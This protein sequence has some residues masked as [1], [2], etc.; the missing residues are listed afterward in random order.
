MRIDSNTKIS[1][2]IRENALSIEVLA[3]VNRNFEK[4]R[5]PILRKVLA[6]RVNVLQAAKMGGVHPEVLLQRLQSIGFM[7][8]FDDLMAYEHFNISQNTPIK[9]ENMNQKQVVTLDVRP[10]LDSGIDPFNAI[11]DALKKLNPDTEQLQIINTFEPIPLLNIIKNKG[12]SYRTERP[13]AGEVHCYIYKDE[14]AS[15]TSTPNSPTSELSYE[16]ALE[17]FSGKMTEIDV[18][19]LEMPMP[20]VKILETIEVMNADEAVF[21]HHKK[22]P[23]Y[24]MPE[25]Q[26]RGF[27]YQSQVIDQDNIKLIIYKA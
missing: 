27:V 8:D 17:R 23:Q 16:S 14:S 10:I 4:L 15:A 1:Q 22:L 12:Y 9:K 6:P 18:R 26:Q 2:I 7:V 19:D 11:M 21:V 5:N 13:T 3:S 20:M 25:L 24:L